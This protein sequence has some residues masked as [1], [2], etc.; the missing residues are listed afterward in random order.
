MRGLA[1]IFLI[2]ILLPSKSLFGQSPARSEPVAS[3]EWITIQPG[4]YLMGCTGK[5]NRNEPP[6]QTVRIPLS[7]DVTK[8]QV[9]HEQWKF[10][11]GKYRREWIPGPKHPA[12]VRWNDAN[13]FVKRMNEKRDGYRYRLLTDAEWEYIARAQGTVTTTESSDRIRAYG[14]IIW[15]DETVI[16]LVTRPDAPPYVPHAVW[17]SGKSRVRHR[18]DF[19]MLG[20]STTYSEIH[21]NGST[22]GMALRKGRFRFVEH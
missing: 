17:T 18:Q 10:V 20:A 4:E 6:P 12:T 7:F 22:T 16:G 19:P 1:L 3:M 2:A 15:R 13:D 9:T 5:C 8:Y 14:E 11:T 21:R